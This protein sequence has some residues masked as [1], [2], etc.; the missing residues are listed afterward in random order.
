MKALIIK[1][2][3]PQ[4]QSVN[5]DKWAHGLLK[6]RN[7]PPQLVFGHP[8]R[9][10]LPIHKRAFAPEWQK[11][12]REVDERV[13]LK[14][15]RLGNMYSKTARDLPPLS[16]WTPVAVQDSGTRKWTRYGTIIETGA[17]RDYLIRLT[18]GRVWRRNCSFICKRYPADP[19]HVDLAAGQPAAQPIPCPAT[20]VAAPP[21]PTL[22][23]DPM[24]H[25]TA[26]APLVLDRPPWPPGPSSCTSRSS[27]WHT[28]CPRTPSAAPDS[29][30][31]T[32]CSGRSPQP[33]PPPTTTGLVP[34]P[35]LSGLDHTVD[36]WRTRRVHCPTQRF[37]EQN[38]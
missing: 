9:D 15:Q 22:P 11:A 23:L 3:Y 17:H 30:R 29:L 18:S 20:A 26:A 14:K 33:L 35:P 24:A 38:S 16:V 5:H 8:S 13:T 27:A 25:R 4:T 32:K 34:A 21:V 7:T 10:T 6:W 37:I 2:W 28:P 36:K 1:C 31:Q 19:T 12:A